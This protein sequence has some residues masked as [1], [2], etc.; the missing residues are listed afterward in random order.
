V[1][2]GLNQHVTPLSAKQAIGQLQAIEHALCPACKSNEHGFYPACK[3]HEHAFYPACKSNRS[4]LIYCQVLSLKLAF[5][6][7][8][9]LK[10]KK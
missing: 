1:A 8:I 9:H 10:E 3:S 5:I 2:L 6:T 4:N 7:A